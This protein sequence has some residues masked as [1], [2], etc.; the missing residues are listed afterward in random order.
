MK[1]P[2]VRD[3]RRSIFPSAKA[4]TH[5]RTGVI[6][7]GR[8]ILKSDGESLARLIEMIISAGNPNIITILYKTDESSGFRMSNLRRNHPIAIN[9]IIERILSIKSLT[10]RLTNH[11]MG[12]FITVCGIS[13]FSLTKPVSCNKI[14]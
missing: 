4:M 6:M 3:S 5:T 13:A 7:A 14:Y 10:P 9:K 12:H 2:M 11:I 1:A 8:I